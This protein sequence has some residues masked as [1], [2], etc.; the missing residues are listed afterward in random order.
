ME[1]VTMTRTPSGQSVASVTLKDDDRL[2]VVRTSTGA[3]T[4][5]RWRDG[6][7]SYGPEF[8]IG[9]QSFI[10]ADSDSGIPRDMLLAANV[11]EFESTASLHGNIA[12][13][14]GEFTG[15]RNETAELS[16]ALAFGTHS[17]LCLRVA[18]SGRDEWE[19]ARFLEVQSC[20]CRH[21][22]PLARFDEHHLWQLAPGC[23]PTFLISDPR[24]S[25]SLL[26]F[27]S[28][29]QHPGFAVA[30]GGRTMKRRFSAFIIESD[31]SKT[32]PPNSFARIDA[33][34]QIRPRLANADE[35]KTIAEKYQSKLLLYG[36]RQRSLAKRVEV[37]EA[38]LDGSARALASVLRSCFPDDQALQQRIGELLKPMDEAARLDV[39]S[40]ESA[41]VIQ[42]L[43]VLCHEGAPGFYVGNVAEIA[44]G[45]LQMLKDDLRLSSR[46]VGA[47]LKMFGLIANRDNR[48]FRLT[49]TN[50]VKL[51]IHRLGRSLDVPFFKGEIT[52]CEF[53]EATSRE[54]YERC[55]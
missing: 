52:P 15:V 43:L 16:A 13:V 23:V 51:R 28:A 36:L 27:L 22:L 44:N 1:P 18:V 24:P 14:I 47:I 3:T 50:A 31:D 35:L 33:T 17:N 7:A 34:P 39:A 8:Q 41:V 54:G 32:G 30:R 2:E 10:A 11:E 19:A 40:R 6:K 48:G 46:R 42:A 26:N 12:A 25:Q 20:F 49:L 55:V 29:T 37:D 9:S 21:A 4:L 53:C 38:G 5:L 45:I